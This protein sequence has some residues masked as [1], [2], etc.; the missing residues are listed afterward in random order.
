MRNVK[1]N[2]TKEDSGKINLSGNQVIEVVNTVA[3][4]AKSGFDWLKCIRRNNSDSQPIYIRTLCRSWFGQ[5]A[6]LYSDNF[7]EFRLEFIK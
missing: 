6:D 4:V 7:K 5:L 3:D 1:K 2:R